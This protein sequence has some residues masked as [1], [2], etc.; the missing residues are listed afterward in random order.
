MKIKKTKIKKNFNIITTIIGVISTIIM[1]I[2]GYNVIKLGMLPS[3]YLIIIF[4]VISI[5]Y[6]ILLLLTLVK[7]I[8]LKIKMICSLFFIMFG[9][10]FGFGIEY[11]D[12]TIS[13]LDNINDKLVQSENYYLMTLSS[14]NLKS[15]EDV[16]N[17][18][19][20]IYTG[21]NTTNLEKAIDK[22]SEKTFFKEKKF[23]IAEEMLEDL[24][25][26]KIDAVLINDAIKTLIESE[27]SHLEIELKEI[28]KIIVL[29]EKTNVAKTVDVTKEVFN[30]YVAGGDSYG[31]IEN[32][33]NTD[34]NLI[35]TVDPIDRKILLT[36]IPR[37]YY[38]NLYTFGENAYDKLTHA[39]YYGI[40]ESILAVEKLLDIEINYYVKVNFSTIVGLIDAIGGV[41]VYSDYNFCVDD[42]CY[43][44]GYNNLNGRKAL[45]FARERH[46]FVDGDV[47]RVKNQQN[48]LTAIINKVTSSTALITNYTD[49]LDSLGGSFSTNIE[50][51]NINKLVK[52]QINDMRGWNIESQNLVGTD[53]ISSNTY[54]F[55]G[56]ELYVMKQDEE[57]VKQAKERIIEFRKK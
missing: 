56:Q 39:G 34:V 30:V 22:L 24:K 50:T 10:A 1:I 32:V 9:I 52:M 14:S 54:T 19:I 57:S 36:S 26:N 3:K 21:G 25:K 23:S 8:K 15:V 2:F 35:A 7:K 11:L 48:V 5:I 46:S 27:L 20:G 33:T 31:S 4:A 43:K 28:D 37:D 18:T 17:K 6:V 29:I 41:D 44:K 47:Q 51:N 12:K 38:V 53:F 16:K 13:F 40:D 45:A 42:L 49:I 55:P